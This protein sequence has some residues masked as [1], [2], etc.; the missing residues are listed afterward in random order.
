MTGVVLILRI[1]APQEGPHRR[2]FLLRVASLRV[3]EGFSDL[4]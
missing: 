4:N 1:L 2:Y 3:L